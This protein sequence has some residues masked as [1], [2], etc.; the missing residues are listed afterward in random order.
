MV[1]DETPF[2]AR[3]TEDP[4]DAVNVAA[5]EAP[6]AA[7]STTD[8]LEDAGVEVAATPLAAISEVHAPSF[9]AQPAA[10]SLEEEARNAVAHETPPANPSPETT[11]S[12]KTAFISRVTKLVGTVL[13]PPPI[14]RKRTRTL[15]ANFNPRRSR[16]IAKLSPEKTNK[17]ATSV[18]RQLGFGNAKHLLSDEDL[19]RYVRVFDQ[20]LS[21][22]HVSALASLL[23]WEAPPAGQEHSPEAVLA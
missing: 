15:P 16:R 12:P 20:P 11:L 2:A 17:A 4:L 14:S 6:P 22:E 3:S 18:Y 21:R 19:V 9:A 1:I 5:A 8:P 23:G 13:K 10:A 7:R